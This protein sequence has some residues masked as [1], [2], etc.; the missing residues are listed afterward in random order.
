MPDFFDISRHLTAEERAIQSSVRAFVDARVLPVISDHFEKG[1]FPMDLIPEIA[2]MG[3][4]GCNLKGYGCAGLSQA[5]YGL[6]MQE[7]ERG[8]S[9]IRSFA[10]VPGSL[11]MYPIH[12]YGSEA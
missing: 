4:L 3:L 5:G 2:G 7:L 6:A 11:V 1:T 12:A 9:G 8:D 10:S